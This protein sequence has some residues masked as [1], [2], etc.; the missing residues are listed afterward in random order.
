MFVF[1]RDSYFF[2]NTINQFLKQITMNNLKN[3]FTSL[4]YMGVILTITVLIL[5]LK[6]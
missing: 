6:G 2:N 1:N 4:L 5:N 3:I